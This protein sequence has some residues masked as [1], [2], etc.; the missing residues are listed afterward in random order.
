MYNARVDTKADTIKYLERSGLP[1][2]TVERLSFIHV[3]GTK[4][5]VSQT[6]GNLFSGSVSHL[7]V[8]VLRFS[9]CC[10]CNP[11]QHQLVSS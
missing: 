6:I 11:I 3:A 4:G 9:S 10:T 5:K 7:F 8:W 1:L 2:E